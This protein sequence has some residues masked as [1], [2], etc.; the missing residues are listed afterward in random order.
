M[1]LTNLALIFISIFFTF[2]VFAQDGRYYAVPN[3][4]LEFLNLGFRPVIQQS[5]NNM[6]LVKLNAAQ[7]TA[8]SRQM[9]ENKS[10]CGGFKDVQVQMEHKGIPLSGI[11]NYAVSRPALVKKFDKSNATYPAQVNQL[12]GILNEKRFVQFLTD[13]SSFPDRYANNDN[14]VK[15]AQWLTDYA[16]R[17]A[18]SHGR[19]D[20]SIRSVATTD[21]IQPSVL[22]KIS[23]TDPSLPGVLLGGHM[24]S[25][26]NNKPAA[27]DDGTGVA[28]VMEVYNSVLESGLKFKRDLYFAFYAAEEWGL[29]GSQNIVEDFVAKKI[30]M[31]S[32]LQ[33]DMTGFKSPQDTQE[34]YFVNDN[35]DP[36]LTLFLKQ[37][38]ETYLKIPAQLIGDTECGYGCSDHASWTDAGFSSAFPFEASFANYNKTLHT[39]QDTMALVN[40]T[41]AMK[42]VRLGAAFAVETADPK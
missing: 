25:Y 19:T 39:S 15:A 42:Y 20:I 28:T 37:L 10:I 8:L 2:Q 31:R 35:V 14:G 32:I 5:L 27:D 23:G 12:L 36:Q 30:A 38:T 9:H 13:F 17:L 4:N 6:S 21:F 29:Y 22:V 26:R 11:L 18:Q 24:D 16:S 40:S 7:V 34:L 41:H 1:R 3:E 33:F